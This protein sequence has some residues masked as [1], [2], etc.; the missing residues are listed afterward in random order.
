MGIITVSRGSFSYGKEVA[1]K[2]AERL[3]YE[4]ISR[5][6]LIETSAKEFDVPEVKLIK[7]IEDAPTFLDRFTKGKEKYVAYIQSALL[8]LLAKDNVVYHGFAGHYFVKDIPRILKVRINAAMDKRA[9]FVM[10]RD[11]VSKE[12]AIKIIKK[13]DEI[14]RR[15]SKHLY[16]IDTFT[17]DLYDLVFQIDTATVDDVVD[18]ICKT[19]SFET[20]RITPEV[21][22][23]LKERAEA[24]KKKALSL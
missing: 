11:G 13:L 16:G 22:E 17:A 20:F 12:E 6:R 10:K 18:V 7:A 23:M 9:E 14:R 3:G 4:I 19:L 24:V 21:I 8:K 1:E 5:E 2:V 15:W